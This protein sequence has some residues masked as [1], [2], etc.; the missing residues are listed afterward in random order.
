MEYLCLVYLEKD[1]WNAVPDR[2]CDNC[3]DAFRRAAC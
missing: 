1:K 2:E 3:G